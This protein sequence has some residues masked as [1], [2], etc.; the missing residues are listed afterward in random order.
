MVRHGSSCENV[1]VHEGRVSVIWRERGR[2][3]EFRDDTGKALESGAGSRGGTC[4]SQSF[5]VKSPLLLPG[6]I[7]AWWL[8]KLLLLSDGSCAEVRLPVATLDCLRS[9]L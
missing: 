4:F 1:R 2:S 8:L 5:V 9:F 6:V 7:V 3:L